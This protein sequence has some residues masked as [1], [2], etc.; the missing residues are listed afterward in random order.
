MVAMLAIAAEPKLTVESLRTEY[1][2]NPSGLDET[3]PRLSWKLTAKGRGA[4]QTAYQ[5]LVA[6]SVGLLKRNRADL[7]DSGKVAS[8]E[9]A[10]IV[11][12][13]K[14]LGSREQCFWKVRSYSG[15]D[16]A[17]AW[18]ATARWS[19]GLLTPQEWTARWISHKDTSALHQSRKE[20]YLPAARYYRKEFQ[21][22]GKVRRAVLYS[23]AL[24]IYDAYV[25]G[26]R[27]SE[28]MFAPG[29]SDYRKRAYYNT[30]DVTTL[31]EHG[32]NVLGAV[33]ADGW[34]S[35]YVGYGLLV[36]YGP[37]KV[38][39]YFY[40]KTP[41]LLA[42]LEIEFE[43]GERVTI[44][45]D[46]TWRVSTGAVS[47]ADILMGE[48]YDARLEPQS[49]TRAGFD[50]GKWEPA[51]EAEKN[52][53]TR[54]TFHDRAGAREVELGFVRPSRMQ[55]YS[56]PPVRPIEE[57]RPV[58]VV[59]Q[60][61]G[62]YIFDLGQNISGVARL[63]VRG[64]AGA[65]V[66]L[67][68]GEMLHADGRLMTENLRKAR[69]IDTYILRGEAAGEIWTPRFTYHG[70]R[71]V[72]VTGFPGKPDRDAITGVVVHSAT[73]LVSTFE[74]S[75]PMANQLFRNIV[76]TQRANFVEI[77]TDCPQ[78]DERLGWTGDAQA[79]AR[80][81]TYNADVAAF[82][83]KWL[84]D[85]DE[86]QQDSGAFPDY[87]PYP[88]RH[89][90][91]GAAHGT[92]W[93]DAGVICPY[94][95]YKAYGDT[96]VIDRHWDAMMRFMRFRH[97]NS[98]QFQGA[99]VGNE[100]GDWLSIGSRTPIEFIDA[101]YFARTS[102]LMAE[103]ARVTRRQSEAA[104]FDDWFAKIR[105]R[106]AQ[107]YVLEAG[108]LKVDNQTAYALALDADLLSGEARVGAARRLGELIE[109][110]KFRMTTGF[111]GTKVLLP[112]LSANH[113]NDLAARLFQSREFPS[114]GYEVDNGATTMWE[115]WNSY[116]KNKGFFEPSMNSFS[117]YAFGAVAEWM[118]ATL[119]GIDTDG[120]GFA[121]IAIK[122]EPP[123]ENSNPDHAPIH[124]VSASYDS[125]RGPIASRWK[126]T[127]QDFELEA[128]IPANTHATV[129]VP[130]HAVVEITESGRPLAR[131]KGVKFVRMEDGRAVLHVVSGSYR[132]RSRP[133]KQ[134]Q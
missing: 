99:K 116:T 52:G 124:W 104:M 67:R 47:E 131:A 61:P 54:A 4:R 83:T 33:L 20:L 121:R 8:S 7:W 43:N 105:A 69:S 86:A 126:R 91:S 107:D 112:V 42:Q 65:K 70:F 79:Y 26:K 113:R 10:Q 90:G 134:R 59:E 34:Y 73:P 78:R 85:L 3:A 117:H 95:M 89:G 31:V 118:F 19:M 115:R 132:F 55:A 11:Y 81:A 123:S 103:M 130:A 21:S 66:R 32:A 129:Y 68:F 48:T 2:E 44:G 14:V 36:G 71:Y 39:R 114:W 119:A 1:L 127:A 12:R 101:V 49:W 62:V 28:R 58:S 35:G 15:S 23:S 56:A 76:W 82:F 25:N 94:M 29:W 102:R 5:I 24:G 63:K 46:E 80:T 51:I 50:A 133:E 122:P 128:S 53:S 9:T 57:I 97:S 6:S 30:Y 106:F 27:V 110:N 77:P 88:M 100:W 22:A 18:S 84:D 96:R 93:M 72:E 87:A 38:G 111:L 60:A 75:D 17:S 41:A 16:K 74:T 64:Q 120:A 125:I 37:N 92:A 109:R 108:R 40:G 13:G 45:S 98:P